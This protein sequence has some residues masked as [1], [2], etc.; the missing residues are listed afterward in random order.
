M[1]VGGVEHPVGCIGIGEAA[2]TFEQGAGNVT[3]PAPMMSIDSAD[4][5]YATP[6]KGCPLYQDARS[7]AA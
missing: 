3:L 6:L 2:A 1:M 7:A 4:V 5:A